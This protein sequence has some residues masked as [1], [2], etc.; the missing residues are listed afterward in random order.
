MTHFVLSETS[1]HVNVLSILTDLKKYI[2]FSIQLRGYIDFYPFLVSINFDGKRIKSRIQSILAINHKL[3]IDSDLFFNLE[4]FAR[5]C[6]NK[7]FAIFYIII[8][9]ETN[10]MSD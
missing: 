4:V 6:N 1:K 8:T 3:L 9:K 5:S 10:K 2:C 7:V